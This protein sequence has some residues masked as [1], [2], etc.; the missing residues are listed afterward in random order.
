[1]KNNKLTKINYYFWD[2]INYYFLRCFKK[3][4][5]I[6]EIHLNDFEKEDDE[7]DGEDSEY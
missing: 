1:M 6:I 4:P 2:N 3:K 7:N 5:D